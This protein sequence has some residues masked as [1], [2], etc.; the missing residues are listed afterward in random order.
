MFLT[1]T[2]EK[3]ENTL[4]GFIYIVYLILSKTIEE[5]SFTKTFT[6]IR[7]QNVTFSSILLTSIG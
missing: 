2:E 5:W 4:L 7:H 3:T 6:T 1:W